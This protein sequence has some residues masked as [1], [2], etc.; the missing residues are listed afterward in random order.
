MSS[1]PKIE[2]IK[3][4]KYTS[5]QSKYFQCAKMPMRSVVLGPS[6]SGKSILMVLLAKWIMEH[7][8]DA[9]VLI[10]T[11]RDELDKQIEGV[12]RN[13]GVIPETAPSPRITSRSKFIEAL[14][15]LSIFVPGSKKR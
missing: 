9:R 5:K 13:A 14:T 4:N 6:G 3:L 7:D 8:P 12:M 1:Y 2:P 10:I 15:S 11:D